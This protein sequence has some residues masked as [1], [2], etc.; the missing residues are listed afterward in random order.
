MQGRSAIAGAVATVVCWAL[1]CTQVFAAAGGCA[2]AASVADEPA[3][4]LG[5]DSVLCLVNSERARRGLAP[6]R[7]S[8]PLT[9]SARRHSRDMVA[10]RYF[11]HVSPGGLN[12]RQRVVRA[13]YL[14]KR[15]AARVGETIVWGTPDKSSPADLVRSLMTSRGHRRVLLDARYRDA[16]VGFAL[17]APLR[18]IDGG[19]TLTLA[20]GRR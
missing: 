18:G 19:A 20:F 9:R 5:S 16:G 12:A 2:R 13:G 15:R 11:S 3:L 1:T 4:Q 8:P 17:G 7:P 14:R 10:R 6:L